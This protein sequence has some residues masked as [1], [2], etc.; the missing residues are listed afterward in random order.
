MPFLTFN[1]LSTTVSLSAARSL[2]ETIKSQSISDTK[3]F[4]SYRRADRKYVEAVV[5]LLK[6]IGVSVYIDYLDETLEDKTN[7]HVAGILRD[8]IKL[9]NKFILLATPDSGNSKWMPW[10]LGLGDRIVNYKNVAILPLT[11]DSSIW[12]DQEYGKIYGHIESSYHNLENGR[13]DWYIIFPNQAKIKLKDWL[14][15]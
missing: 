1:K 5:R 4:L 12:P 7:E 3:V 2:N 11:N 10:E 9:S 13:D 8:R 15:T 14:I 6:K